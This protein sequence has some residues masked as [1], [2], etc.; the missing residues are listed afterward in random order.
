MSFLFLGQQE[1]IGE[2]NIDLRN[3]LNPRGQREGKQV[4][5]KDSE[6]RVVTLVEGICD[7]FSTISYVQ[8]ADPQNKTGETIKEWKEVSSKA[9]KGKNAAYHTKM[10]QKFMSYCAFL[11]DEHVRQ[12]HSNETSFRRLRRLRPTSNFAAHRHLPGPYRICASLRASTTGGR[13]CETD[14]VV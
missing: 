12:S 7:E 10:Q 9:R 13:D 5:Y 8:S 14:S 1:K 3:R 2:K 4:E 6:L 11:L